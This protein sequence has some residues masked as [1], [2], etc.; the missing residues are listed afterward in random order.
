MST[1]LWTL[2]S[3]R[4]TDHELDHLTLRSDGTY[5]LVRGGSTK[6]RSEKTGAWISGPVLDPPEVLL[7][8]ASYP[9]EIHGREIRLLINDDLGEWYVKTN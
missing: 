2:P 4:P 7:D 8:H 9:V 5:D 3:D 1:N 6:D